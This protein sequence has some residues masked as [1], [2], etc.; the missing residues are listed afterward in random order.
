MKGWLFC[1][2]CL[3]LLA[4]APLRAAAEDTLS[5]RL[6]EGT[7]V[8]PATVDPALVDVKDLLTRNLPYQSLKLLDKKS[9]RLPASQQY[10]LEGKVFVTL[11]GTGASLSVK[12]QRGDDVITSTVTLQPGKPFTLV[13]FRTGN[14]QLILILQTN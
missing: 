8:T 10:E 6:V 1:T 7:R 5:L 14:G 11:Q 12:L 3:A 9:I 13:G 2:L 4:L